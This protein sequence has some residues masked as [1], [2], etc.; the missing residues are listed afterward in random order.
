MLLLLMCLL[1]MPCIVVVDDG[2]EFADTVACD[3][4]GFDVNSF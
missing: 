3:C 4:V 2:N 1:L